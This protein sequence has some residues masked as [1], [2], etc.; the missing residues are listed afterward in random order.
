LSKTIFV[1]VLGAEVEIFRIC[2]GEALF[3]LGE[4]DVGGVGL[5]GESVTAAL[6]VEAPD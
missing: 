3:D 6:G 2:F 1:Y 4:G 5:D